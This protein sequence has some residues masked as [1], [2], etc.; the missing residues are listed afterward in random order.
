MEVFGST[1]SCPNCWAHAFGIYPCA[2]TPPRVDVFI[3]DSS[4][5]GWDSGI[6]YGVGGVW[7]DTTVDADCDDFSD[8]VDDIYRCD[9]SGC[10][11]VCDTVR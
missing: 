5:S 6:E 11:D 10:G 4:I 1:F 9:V 3:R 2:T 8:N 7:G